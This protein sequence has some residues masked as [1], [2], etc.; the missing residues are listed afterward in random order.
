MPER[1]VESHI[2]RI[3]LFRNL[4]PSDLRLVAQAF[5]A[6]HYFPGEEVFQQ[7]ADAQGLYALTSGQGELIQRGVDGRE[8]Q[9]GVVRSGHHVNDQTLFQAGTETAT[10]RI[11]E[12]ADILFLSRDRF[13][14]LISINPQLKYP[15][16]IA[17]ETPNRSQGK[18]FKGQ[19]ENEKVLYQT[20]R[21]WWAYF[22]MLW[23]PIAL[24]VGLFVV[25]FAVDNLLVRLLMILISIAANIAIFVYL[26][27][28]WRNDSIILTDQRLITIQHNVL[29]FSEQYNEIPLDN[30]NGVNVDLP[31]LDPMAY[32]FGYQTVQIKT[33][34]QAASFTMGFVPDA[35]DVQ[36][37]ILEDIRNVQNSNI[38][39]ENAIRADIYKWVSGDPNEEYMAETQADSQQEQIYRKHWAILLRDMIVPVLL[40]LV[41]FVFVFGVL[42]NPDVDATTRMIIVALATLGFLVGALLMYYQY[43]DWKNDLYAVNDSTITFVH[44]R[45]LWLQNEIDQ[46]LLERVDNVLAESAGIARLFGYGNVNIS[47]LGADEYKVFEGVG[48]PLTI[49]ADISRR[50]IK[51]SQ[52]RPSRRGTKESDW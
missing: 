32:A 9:L 41:A 33:A 31:P 8:R 46:V 29:N 23:I 11:T 25:A 44:R 4:S 26:Y 30:I 13:A 21:H 43:W 27:I 48:D 35:D 40:M 45:P 37:I 42:I 19:R 34:G 52:Y 16:G 17:D 2:R 14:E 47:L 3:P 15:M 28:E 49:Q 39:D 51:N 12:E 36:K 1:F 20:R 24:A 6:R 50:L 38:P 22:R 18:K 5:E 7:Y 10:L